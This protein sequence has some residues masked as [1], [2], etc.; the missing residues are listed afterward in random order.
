MQ[1][2]AAVHRDAILVSCRESSPS[3][4]VAGRLSFAGA[5]L[6]GP[7]LPPSWLCAARGVVETSSGF[8]VALLGVR[9]SICPSE[10]EAELGDLGEGLREGDLS[11]KNPR[12][13][14]LFVSLGGVGVSGGLDCAELV[15]RTPFLSDLLINLGNRL[16]IGDS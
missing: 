3:E 4:S 9:C 6:V 2:A 11:P 16:D 14:G 8:W 1:P 5:S 7:L 10:V 12:K 15:S 13:S